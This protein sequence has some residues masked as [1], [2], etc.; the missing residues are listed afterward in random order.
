MQ[1]C[2][3]ELEDHGGS[4]CGQ[5]DRAS[6][7]L[8]PGLEWLGDGRVGELGVGGG[9]SAPQRCILRLELSHADRH[10]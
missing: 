9:E 5:A 1:Y 2:T 7:S 8:P 3:L 10:V 4:V 6:S